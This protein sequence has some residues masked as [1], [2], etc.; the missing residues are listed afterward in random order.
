MVNTVAIS[1][2]WH[3]ADKYFN[4]QTG[5]YD[6]TQAMLEVK[7]KQILDNERLKKYR[8]LNNECASN[9]KIST[10]ISS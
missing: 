9:N 7:I 8:R 5:T 1:R 6:Y 10:D 3:K 4:P 2:V